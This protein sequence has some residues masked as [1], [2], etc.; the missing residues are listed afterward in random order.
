MA[1]T[2]AAT[3][4]RVVS[5]SL[6]DSILLLILGGAAVHRCGKWLF[7]ELA[8]AAAVR[9]RR[10]KYVFLFTHVTDFMVMEAPLG[11]EA[12]SEENFR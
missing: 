2:T 12:K 11:A 10:G 6:K 8:S 7:P 1:G 9:L 4:G 3:A 5:R